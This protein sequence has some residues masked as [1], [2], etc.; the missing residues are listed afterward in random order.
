MD[1]KGTQDVG[2]EEKDQ[3]AD[4]ATDEVD[5]KEQ[6]EQLKAQLDKTTSSVDS[7][8][9]ESERNL[10]RLQSSYTQQINQLTAQTQAERE[11]LEDE[12][13]S[14]RVKGMDE[15][16]ALRYEN[17]RMAEKL[18]RAAQRQRE[19]QQRAEMA[20]QAASY[21]QQFVNLGV[22][23]ASLNTTGSLQELADSGWKAL[24]D[25]RT[26]ERSQASEYQEQLS[27]IQ[28]QL[29]SLRAEEPDP[30]K[31]AESKGDKTPPKVASH[32][33]G[34]P[35]TRTMYDVQKSLESTFGYIPSE[36]EVF[37]AV[38]TGRLPA[39]ILPGLEGL[40]GKS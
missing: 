33:P 6:A 14:E 4:K 22:P 18:E 1:P 19:M 17:A 37:R 7:L 26:Q 8:K 16:E 39:S 38:E 21:V 34:Q 27:T 25:I 24:A 20:G 3:V 36:E 35:G 23:A 9:A 29:D 30:K 31:I 40:P 28:K 5:W 11:R 15:A 2:A 13:H 10:R 32:T 12:F